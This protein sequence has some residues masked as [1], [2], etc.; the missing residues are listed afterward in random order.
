MRKIAPALLVL[1]LLLN[2]SACTADTPEESTSDAGTPTTTTT[3]T[4]STGNS[5]PPSHSDTGTTTGHSTGDAPTTSAD[6]PASGLTTTTTTRPITVGTTGHIHRFTDSGKA[7]TC[8]ADGYSKK[9]CACGETLSETL[10]ALGHDFVLV[11]AQAAP[12]R[13]SLP[14]VAAVASR[15]STKPPRPPATALAIGR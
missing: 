4:P 14:T 10:P 5:T 12:P 13:E 9:A 8:T 6:K 3:A 11:S 7:A 1:A 15:N 2:L